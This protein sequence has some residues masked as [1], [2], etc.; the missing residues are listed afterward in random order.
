[1]LLDVEA[2]MQRVF[3]RIGRSEDSL[4]AERFIEYVRR[5]GPVE[6]DKAYKMIHI[7]FPDFRDFEGVINGAVRS[8][9]I[10]MT[11]TGAGAPMLSMPRDQATPSPAPT[12]S[13]DTV[14]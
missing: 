7:Y 11:F 3:S 5:H 10:T 13:P 14:L 9:Q 4:Q 2:D 6:Y 1:M 8:G 12:I